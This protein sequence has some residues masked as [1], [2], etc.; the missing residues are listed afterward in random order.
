MSCIKEEISEAASQKKKN[1]CTQ[2]V[3]PN[4]NWYR[5]LK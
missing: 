1:I 2:G 4:Y 3:Q 5:N